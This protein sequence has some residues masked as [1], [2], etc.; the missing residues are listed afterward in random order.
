MEG[1]ATK[2]FYFLSYLKSYAFSLIN[3]LSIIDGDYSETL[4]LLKDEFLDSGLVINENFCKL[5]ENKP[6]DEGF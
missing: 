2:L 6:N 5:L 3:H 4:K 1:D